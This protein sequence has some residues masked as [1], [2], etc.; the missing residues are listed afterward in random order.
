LPTHAEKRVV[1]Y[2]PE[3]MFDL[4]AGIER[5]PE[6]LPW[7]MAARIK[8]RET[9]PGTDQSVV[10]ADLVIGFKMIR[11]R[12][13]SKVTMERPGRIDVVYLE[14]PLKHLTNH[15]RFEPLPAGG[16]LVDFYVDFEF[17]SKLLQTIIGALFHEALR[18]MVSAFDARAKQLYGK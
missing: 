16:T 2:T 5:Y 7:C 15:W 12:Y 14:G 9:V 8:S 13:T 6:F 10:I 4:V 11:E 17:R 1:P 3:Q 18:R